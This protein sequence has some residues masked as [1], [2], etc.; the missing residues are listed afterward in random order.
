MS[1]RYFFEDREGS[2]LSEFLRIPYGKREDIVFTEGSG[3]LETYV[4]K[5]LE[6]PENTAVVYLDTM[7]NNLSTADIYTELA[8]LSRAANYRC[9]V[10]PIVCVEYYFL[11]SLTGS[12]VVK[13]KHLVDLCV[14]KNYYL[15]ESSLKTHSI[16]SYDTFER[17]CKM[18]CEYSL[19]RCAS[20]RRTGKLSKSH[21]YTN[22]HCPCC[23]KDSACVEPDK[24]LLE[25]ASKFVSMFPCIPR[26]G[27]VKR[28]VGTMEEAWEE[29][30][31][32]VREFN[33]WSSLYSAMAPKDTFLTLTPIR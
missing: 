23:G 26:D 33:A 11:R 6:S 7:P 8:C 22:D 25:K 16:K 21:H 31:R 19:Y 5:H 12:T 29:H 17:F 24:L 18:V 20:I 3:N 32:L 10:I 2:A 28:R 4:G 30:R 14:S 1:M 27:E 9:V 13:D 15:N